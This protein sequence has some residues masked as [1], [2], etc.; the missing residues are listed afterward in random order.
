MQPVLVGGLFIGLLSALPFVSIAN[1][2]CLW[3]TSG[4]V[5]TA[6]LL[7]SGRSGVISL[8][9]GAMGGFQAGIVGAVIYALVSVPIQLV[10]MPFQRELIDNALESGTDIPPACESFS[11]T[12][13]LGWN[14][15]R[16]W[17][18]LGSCWCS[19]RCSQASVAS[20]GR[21]SFSARP[22]LS[23]FRHRHHSSREGRGMGISR[24]P[25][26]RAESV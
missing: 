11:R 14:W 5:V 12:S 4:G 23:S 26:L 6:Y 9:E 10:T 22:L 1:C 18:V 24:V 19:V 3:V 2:C 25:V 8:G 15:D 17:P 13:V 16:C 21:L 7:Q 20:W